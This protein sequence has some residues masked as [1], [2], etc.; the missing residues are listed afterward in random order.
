MHALSFLAIKVTPGSTGSWQA[1]VE[2]FFRLLSELDKSFELQ[3]ELRGRTEEQILQGPLAD[4]MT[5]VG[6]LAMLRRL[7]SS[8]IPKENF[9]EAVIRIGDISL[10]ANQ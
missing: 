10:E 4:A 5:H 1:E 6:Q 9:D 7:A 3:L 2:R 8:P